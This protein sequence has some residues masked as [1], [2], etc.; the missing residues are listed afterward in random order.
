MQTSTTDA[1]D[2]L[3]LV[4]QL[5][6]LR[7][8]LISLGLQAPRLLLQKLHLALLLIILGART[9]DLGHSTRDILLEALHLL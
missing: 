8:L 4:K 5:L 9:L 1:A 3:E 6:L 2:L 7:L